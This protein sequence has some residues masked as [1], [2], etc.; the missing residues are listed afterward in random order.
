M[1][2]FF[3]V[4]RKTELCKALSEFMFDTEDALIRI[5][6]SEYMEKHTVSRLLGAPP[7]Y[8]GYDEGGQLTDAV[9]RKPYSVLLFDEMEK[10]HPDVFNVMLQ[11]LDDGRLTD[12][13]GNNVNFRNTICI[14]TSNI[15]S[16]DILDL[17]ANDPGSQDIMRARVTKAM[18]DNFKP[19]FLNRIDE[20]VI[21]NSLDKKALREIVKLE[22]GRLQKRLNERQITLSVTRDALDF[23]ADVGFD[24]I[25]GARP[26]K[27]TIQRELETI[28]AKSILGGE[29][30]DGDSIVV[31]ILNE[32][33]DVRK[34]F[35]GQSSKPTAPEGGAVNTANNY[36][37]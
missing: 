34:A 15:G 33:L 21:F 7:G 36:F 17:D 4:F 10:A 28:V 1:I 12:S 26:L 35:D 18:K 11:L 37:M 29:Y 20:Q 24:P 16:Q 27:R 13:K 31:D 9:R 6:M 23:L 3:M 30:Q 22:I 5:D 19:E 2:S 8:V 25:Y 14:F 32:R